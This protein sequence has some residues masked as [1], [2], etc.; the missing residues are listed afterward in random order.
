MRLVLL[1]SMMAGVSQLTH[2]WR[3]SVWEQKSNLVLLWTPLSQAY[4]C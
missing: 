3:K 2:R 4:R 1:S